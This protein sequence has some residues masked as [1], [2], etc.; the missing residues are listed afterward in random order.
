[1]IAIN[2][3][4]QRG[5]IRL[6]NDDMPFIWVLKCLRVR[7]P[8]NSSNQYQFRRYVWY[9]SQINYPHALLQ[10]DGG[11]PILHPPEH[12]LVQLLSSVPSSPNVALKAPN[13]VYLLA[14]QLVQAVPEHPRPGVP[15]P[16]SH[17]T[18]SLYNPRPCVEASAAA[19]AR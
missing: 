7:R 17:T 2:I 16:L 15:P 14:V 13:V 8:E 19:F 3:S 10:T 11:L 4:L 12:A 1:M 9:K 5:T 18:E 6:Q